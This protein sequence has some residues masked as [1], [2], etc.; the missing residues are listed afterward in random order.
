[1]GA[2]NFSCASVWRS[3][4]GIDVFDNSGDFCDT[5]FL[6]YDI[7]TDIAKQKIYRKYCKYRYFYERIFFNVKQKKDD[8]IN[9]LS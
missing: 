2:I 4:Y 3:K 9:L 5:V 8:I 1:M 7:K 6:V